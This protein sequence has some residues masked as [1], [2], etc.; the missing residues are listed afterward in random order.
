MYY[1][2]RYM[3]L[4]N[5]FS[6]ILTGMCLAVCLTAC[7][8]N[9]Y[10]EVVE[11]AD[12]EEIPMRD[13]HVEALSQSWFATRGT[14]YISPLFT[15]LAPSISKYYKMGDRFED[16]VLAFDNPA[17]GQEIHVT[18]KASALNEERTVSMLTTG[19][20]R[21]EMFFPIKWKYEKFSSIKS[22]MPITMEW[23]IRMKGNIICQYSKQF[24]VSP[25]Q[26]DPYSVY[27]ELDTPDAKDYVAY[28]K[29]LDWGEYPI[30][31]DGEICY[32]SFEPFFFGY[33]SPNNPMVSRLKQEA[34][35]DIADIK[36]GFFGYQWG[37]DY[38][39]EQLVAFYWLM[40]K[41]GVVYSF[42]GTL[43]ST[44][45]E[46]FNNGQGYCTTLTCAMASL[47]LS[48]GISIEF[49]EIPGHMY[50]VVLDQ[51]GNPLYPMDCTAIW[52]LDKTL[53][54]DKQIEMSREYF[55]YML[56][57]SRAEYEENFPF[58][59]AQSPRYFVFPMTSMGYNKSGI[60]S[61]DMPYI[62]GNARGI[63]E[64]VRVTCHK[65]VDRPAIPIGVKRVCF[66]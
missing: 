24:N 49:V 28:L 55:E 66:P 5:L 9:Y 47:C 16:M 61:I 4:T 63:N 21:I 8:K 10:T 36:D 13:L 54:F 51:E 31:E 56:E 46:V 12:N 26:E 35:S 43:L 7:E 53:P 2:I 48:A 65:A 6:R 3:K 14:D 59:E 34:M 50:L 38:V 32:L 40:N 58:I 25:F 41:Y 62:S 17:A 11:E 18:M 45:A 44:F 37:N 64:N 20:E 52:K 30:R 19:D 60:P 39:K 29:T 42:E 22:A 15:Y 1:Y 23:E 33:V 27:W 57:L